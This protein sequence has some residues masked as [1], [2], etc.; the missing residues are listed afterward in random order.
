LNALDIEIGNKNLTCTVRP[1]L[2][3]AV[4]KLIF[5]GKPVLRPVDAHLIDSS[6]QAANFALIP[7]SNRIANATLRWLG[8]SHGLTINNANEPHS[9]HGVG[10]QQPWSVQE[11]GE[12]FLLLSYE[13]LANECWPFDFIASQ[14]L[15]ISENELH[16]TLSITNK[17]RQ[18]APVGLGWHPYFVKREDTSVSFKANGIWLM[19]EDRLPT[20][21]GSSKGLDQSCTD[22]TVDHC[23]ENW[24]GCARLA[25]KELRVTVR[26]NL[27][28]LVVYTNPKM[29]SVAIEPVSHVNNAINMGSQIGVNPEELGI[30]VL[31]PEESFTAQM[32]I[33]VEE[34][35]IR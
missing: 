22:L 27:N 26:S 4:L 30:K 10:W 13:H 23:F 3:G 1:H 18:A 21:L 28:R 32:T 12:E 24:S 14:A 20:K 2:G 16:H 5:R 17:S 8:T 29:D 19:G 11:W 33:S 34:Q 9:I 25:D 15:S 6:R 35:Q 7:Y 31:L